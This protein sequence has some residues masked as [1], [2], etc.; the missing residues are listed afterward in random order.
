MPAQLA[1]VLSGR[2]IAW[3]PVTR[4]PPGAERQRDRAVRVLVVPG[5]DLQR[6]AADVQEQ[7]AAR[8]PAE[9]APGGEEGQPCL[10][11]TGQYLDGDVGLSLDPRQQLIAIDGV[12]DR[13]GCERQRLL[14]ALVFGDLQGLVHEVAQ[15]L[16]AVVCQ[17]VGG[18]EV[19]TEA[20]LGLVRERRQRPAALVGID[21]QQVNGV[22]SHVKHAESHASD[23][24]WS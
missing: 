9:P 5:R 13:R 1:H 21:D 24:T 22:R 15:L 6:T 17:P 10:V 23:A 14:H 7:Q 3:Q 8:G 11:L 12:A 18:I 2:R 19:L 16:R 20:E 4:Q